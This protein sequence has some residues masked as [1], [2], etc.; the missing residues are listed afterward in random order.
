MST[1][2]QWTSLRTGQ[3]KTS[4]H[5][6]SCLWR[7]F[8]SAGMRERTRGWNHTTCHRAPFGLDANMV[9]LLECTSSFPRIHAS[10]PFYREFSLSK[11]NRVT[12][13]KLQQDYHRA[14][15]LHPC[16]SC[17]PSAPEEGAHTIRDGSQ[18]EKSR[19]TMELH[20]C[21]R[22]QVGMP[23]GA[24][25]ATERPPFSPDWRSMAG[26]KENLWAGRGAP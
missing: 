1:P 21:D 4:H 18:Q 25:G 8:P 10:N 12:T 6:L 19:R 9:L 16:R 20:C 15:P 24:D 3:D 14:Y 13:R 7:E 11:Q 5:G 26:E 22:A 23:T 17:N 2:F